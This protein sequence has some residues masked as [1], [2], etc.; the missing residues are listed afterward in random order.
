MP[1][2]AAPFAAD[3]RAMDPRLCDC[4]LSHAV[5]T[6]ATSRASV[7]TARVSP[8]AL[9]EH[10]VAAMRAALDEERWLCDRQ[11][12]QWLAPAY[13]WALVLDSLKNFHRNNHDAGR[14]PRSAE[15]EAIYR[16]TI[17]GATYARQ[18]GTVQRWYDADQRNHATVH[19]VA[20]G[21]RADTAI[22]QAIDSRTG[23]EDWEQRLADSLTAFRECRWPSD[24]LRPGRADV[25]A[26]S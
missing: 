15:W 20:Y 16:R 22:E 10:V 13:R 3:L 1:M 17:P 5:D 7:I 12:P 6:A 2:P 18:L 23:D 11:E 21:A 24:S 4:A 9:A 14:H 26:G 19:A 25:P 8:P